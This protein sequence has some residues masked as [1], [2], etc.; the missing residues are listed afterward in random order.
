MHEL[1][2]EEAAGN[3]RLRSVISLTTILGRGSSGKNVTVNTNRSREHNIGTVL[4]SGSVL[5]V[6]NCTQ[7]N[8]Y[9]APSCPLEKGT[10]GLLISGERNWCNTVL[11]ENDTGA[12]LISEEGNWCSTDLRRKKLVKYCSQGERNWCTTVLRRGKLVHY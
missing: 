6:I 3:V 11:K 7:E 9:G 12:L 2:L 1:A 8:K 5:V 4:N 10:G